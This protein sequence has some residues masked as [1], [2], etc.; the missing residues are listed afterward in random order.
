MESENDATVSVYLGAGS[1]VNGT[2]P[3]FL[4]PVVSSFG[5]A[6]PGEYTQA[7]V[8]MQ[9]AHFGGSM[10]DLVVVDGN[11]SGTIRVLVASGGGHFA[12]PAGANI[13]ANQ[14]GQ[15]VDVG[16]FVIAD[17]NGDGISDIAIETGGSVDVQFGA[18]GGSFLTTQFTYSVPDGAEGG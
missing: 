6:M 3:S 15:D 5:T 18:S 1:N 8:G 16:S 2:N 7:V 12:M 13:L 10:D 17:P 9:T 11:D 14:A 4:S